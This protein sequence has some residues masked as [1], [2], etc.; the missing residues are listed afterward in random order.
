MYDAQRFGAG[1]STSHVRRWVTLVGVACA[2]L[3]LPACD[4]S[5]ENAETTASVGAS[6]TSTPATGGVDPEVALADW[7]KCM[8]ARGL[9]M[10]YLDSGNGDV[11]ES[12]SIP[13]DM[14]TDAL[15]AAGEECD[16]ILERAGRNRDITPE[17]Q[18]LLDDYTAQLVACLSDKGYDVVAAP[19]SAGVEI[20][21]GADVEEFGVAADACSAAIGVPDGLEGLVDS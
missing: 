17:Q 11:T 15:A 18:A 8:E 3:A 10:S 7:R 13:P 21:A 2:A 20:P 19:E 12:Q 6:A 9:D 5:N 1:R 4:S 16:P 14:D